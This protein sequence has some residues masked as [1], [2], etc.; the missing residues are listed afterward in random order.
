MGN[1]LRCSSEAQ[2]HKANIRG[3]AELLFPPP[4]EVFVNSKTVN[5]LKMLV[6]GFVVAVQFS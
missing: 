5:I 3:S 2:G 1:H 4:P 6:G